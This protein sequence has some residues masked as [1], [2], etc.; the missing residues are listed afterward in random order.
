MTSG[1]KEEEDT[2]LQDY[3]DQIQYILSRP[4]I[5]LPGE[6]FRYSND[7]TEL[8][9]YLIHALEGKYVD[10]YAEEKLFDQLGIKEYH[11]EKENGVP[12]CHSDLHLL[13]RD[14]A[15]IGLLVL[16][17]GKWLGKQL[18]S[19]AWIHEST[20]PLVKES[21]YYDYGY[22]WWHRSKDNVAWWKEAGA[23]IATEHDKVIA[24]GHGGQYIIIIRDM[25]M[26]VVTMASDYADGSKAR[27]KIPMVIEEIVPLFLDI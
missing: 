22:Q 1:F 27:S 20:R 18:V 24:L 6:Q 9:G 2:D 12:H 7:G 26:V 16:N 19:Q 25:N 3:P 8:L 10:Q 11:W 13:P 17:D 14:M 5:S 23:R 4:L 15:K 21:I